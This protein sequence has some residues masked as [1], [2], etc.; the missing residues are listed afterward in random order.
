MTP[1]KVLDITSN[2]HYQQSNVNIECLNMVH[3]WHWLAVTGC[4]VLLGVNQ[5]NHFEISS[6]NSILRPVY[7]LV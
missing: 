5:S 7:K 4:Q 3:G 2:G 6:Y 1:N